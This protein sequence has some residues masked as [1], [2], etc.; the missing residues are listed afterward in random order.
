MGL[1]RRIKTL[2]TLLNT[3]LSNLLAG[4]SVGGKGKRPLVGGNVV[5]VTGLEASAMSTASEGI[6]AGDGGEQKSDG[7]KSVEQ[8]F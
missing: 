6:G 4:G 2:C 5:G 8:H 1:R 3:S 7:G